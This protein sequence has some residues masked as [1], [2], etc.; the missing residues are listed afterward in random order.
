VGSPYARSDLTRTGR[1]SCRDGYAIL[2]GGVPLRQAED[3]W[4]GVSTAAEMPPS[5]SS[6]K[7]SNV[8]TVP[9]ISCWM[10]GA[11]KSSTSIRLDH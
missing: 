6:S 7:T 9:K 3:L 5:F 8:A 11:S 1:P 4:D 2:G 10:I